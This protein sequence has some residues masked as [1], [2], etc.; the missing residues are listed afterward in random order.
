M[1]HVPRQSSCD[2]SVL[3]P[4]IPRTSLQAIRNVGL[5]AGATEPLALWSGANRCELS[6]LEGK[7]ILGGTEG[8]IVG[9]SWERVWGG[10]KE[11]GWKEC[12][13]SWK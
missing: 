3:N 11:T 1:S 10:R 7:Q 5:K 13:N 8:Q 12:K 6:V 4:Y 2:L 9:A